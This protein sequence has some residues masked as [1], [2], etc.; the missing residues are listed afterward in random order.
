MARMFIV[1][2][3]TLG[4]LIAAA[5]SA[6]Q[7]Q[8]IVCKP[9]KSICWQ[10]DEAMISQLGSST[11]APASAPAPVAQTYVP[12]GSTTVVIQQNNLPPA[13]QQQM[14]P[15]APAPMAHHPVRAPTVYQQYQDAYRRHTANFCNAAAHTHGMPCGPA[16][17][18]PGSQ[19][20][21]EYS[22]NFLNG[23]KAQFE[24]N[25]IS[26]QVRQLER[27]VNER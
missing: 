19:S 24:N 20:Y 14:A 22:K 26:G 12:A 21:E 8:Q 13:P 9:D 2:L 10:V 6:Q 3:A 4:S 18:M 16:I 7:K 5:A 15:P 17:G 25:S 11:S 27:R 23:Y 1:I